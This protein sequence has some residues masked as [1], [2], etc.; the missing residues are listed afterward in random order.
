LAGSLFPAPCFAVYACGASV[1]FC[2]L[3]GRR[4]DNLAFLDFFRIACRFPEFHAARRFDDDAVAGFDR[5]IERVEVD[6]RGAVLLTLFVF[7]RLLS[8]EPSP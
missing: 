1:G 8:R 6:V 4:R 5:Q 2:V 3:F 7:Y